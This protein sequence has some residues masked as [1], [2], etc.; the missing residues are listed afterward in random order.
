MEHATRET[1]IE[2]AKRA[3][4]EVKGP[5][6]RADFERITGIGN[7][8]IY[9]LFPEGG[10]SEVKRLAGLERHPLQ[11]DRCSDDEL[12][13][14]YHRIASELGDIPSW[15]LFASRGR[16]SSDV[17]RR[18]FGGTQ[19]TLKRYREWIEMHD[20]ESPLVDLLNVKSKHEIPIPPAGGVQVKPKVPTCPDARG[21]E[22][23]P[24]INFR[25]LRHAPINEQGVVFLFGMISY[26]LGFLVEAVHAGYPDCEG[27]RCIDRRRN[28][29]QRARIEFEYLS[30]NFRDHGHDP[31]QC[32]VI[33]CWEHNW[34]ECP[35][36]V[37]ELRRVIDELGG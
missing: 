23:G 18:R 15:A 16:V 31:E 35:L 19:G 6:S 8:H 21:M 28:R 7:Y 29:W 37:I 2:S 20:P 1:I 36:E 10:W 5:L 11:H 9:K 32:D 30:S 3:A 24:P 22:F 12:L 34:P 33:V 13:Q 27:K 26:E 17:V 14:E 25:G 4:A